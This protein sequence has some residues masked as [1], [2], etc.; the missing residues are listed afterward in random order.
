[1][2][3][4]IIFVCQQTI[5]RSIQSICWRSNKSHTE[6]VMVSRVC[7][8]TH[9]QTKAHHISP[10][11]R[12]MKSFVMYACVCMCCPSSPHYH[13]II[14]CFLE[15]P[16]RG[17]PHRTLVLVN[18]N[19][20]KFRTLECVTLF[21]HQPNPTHT[22]TQCHPALRKIFMLMGFQNSLAGALVR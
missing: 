21:T 15:L 9:I 7:E 2:F 14:N 6:F 18:L 4:I 13:S 10:A 11:P 3:V 1:M 22:H 16:F 5:A 12:T 20:R 8:R 19:P 17:L